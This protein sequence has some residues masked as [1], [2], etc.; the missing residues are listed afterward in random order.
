MDD[1]RIVMGD[2]EDLCV[3]VVGEGRDEKRACE[4]QRRG[5]R[6]NAK[7]RRVE[8][9]PAPRVLVA[10]PSHAGDAVLVSHG[11]TLR[12]ERVTRRGA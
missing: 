10:T 1:R 7:P 4:R 9:A 8:P 3:C 11:R 6:G 12:G 2:K 5:P